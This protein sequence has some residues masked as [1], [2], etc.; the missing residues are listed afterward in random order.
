MFITMLSRGWPLIVITA[1][2]ITGMLLEWAFRSHGCDNGRYTDYRAGDSRC[3]RQ[4]KR[5]RAQ[6][7]EAEGACRLLRA[8]FHG[9]F[10]SVHFRYYRYIV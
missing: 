10:H 4:G 8:P 6:F 7:T 5:G 3:R 9:G 1:L 2:A